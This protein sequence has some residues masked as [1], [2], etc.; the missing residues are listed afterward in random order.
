MTEA[1]LNTI[2]LSELNTFQQFILFFLIMI[3][4][5]ILM[6]IAVLKVRERY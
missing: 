1:G 2:N 6:S 5:A 3:G 4:S